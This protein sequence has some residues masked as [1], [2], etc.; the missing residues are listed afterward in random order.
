MKKVD[1]NL[2]KLYEFL[3]DYSRENGFPPTVREMAAHL[4]VKSTSTIAY[5][6]NILEKNGKIR[7]SPSK[8]RALEVLGVEKNDYYNKVNPA[9]IKVPML[10]QITAGA[11]I[12][13]VENHDEVFDLPTSLFN[14]HDMFM[15]TV[16]GESMI[17]AG[18][19]SGDKIILQK[20]DYARNG[21]IVA[22]MID[23]EATVKTFYKENARYRLQP[24]NSSMEPIY[25]TEVSILGKVIGLIRKM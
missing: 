5:Y 23:G 22:A 16:K 1:I 4:D 24:E 6:L 19:H 17:E 11:P 25:T 20:Q 3:K 14:N 8:N 9:F 13:A 10:G 7:K 2:N 21:E 15:L 12:L 18:I